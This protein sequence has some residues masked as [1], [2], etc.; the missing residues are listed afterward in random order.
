MTP[1]P[2]KTSA[3]L[4]ALAL[5]AFACAPDPSDGVEG[6]AQAV[7]GPGTTTDLEPGALYPG[8][9]WLTFPSG[10]GCTGTLISPSHVVT[11][12]HCAV[13]GLP[14]SMAFFDYDLTGFGESRGV[15]RC[16]VLPDYSDAQGVPADPPELRSQCG[17]LPGGVD[18]SLGTQY[19][20]AIV[21]LDRPVPLPW[22]AVGPGSF[23]TAFHRLPTTTPTAGDPLTIV[24]FGESSDGAGDFARRRYKDGVPFLLSS[25]VTGDA[26][27]YPSGTVFPGD[28]G[29]PALHDDGVTSPYALPVIAAH[30]RI[31]TSS[32]TIDLAT[33]FLPGSDNLAWLQ[34][35]MDLDADGRWDTMCDGE[36]Q[37]GYDPNI[38]PNLDTDGD[39]WEDSVDTEPAHYNPCQLGIDTDGDGLD[40][41]VD[42]C[43]LNPAPATV[44]SDTDGI[45][46]VCDLCPMV[47]SD[48][49]DTDEDGRGDP[50][51]ACPD[52]T[53]HP[54][55]L[56]SDGDGFY[57]DCDNCEDVF[58]PDQLDTDGADFIP[59]DGVGDACDNCP[60]LR[61]AGQENCNLDA[62]EALGLYDEGSGLYGL[63][64]ACDPNPCGETRRSSTTRYVNPTTRRVES[65]RLTIDARGDDLSGGTVDATTGFRYC[66][67]DDGETD[68]LDA[69]RACR[70]GSLGRECFIDSLLY[71]AVDD[72]A[73]WRRIA[74][75]SSLPSSASDI[76]AELSSFPYNPVEPRLSDGSIV[77]E[78]DLSTW[79]DVTSD[80]ARWTGPMGAPGEFNGV[81][82][83]RSIASNPPDDTRLQSH[84][85]AGP[86]ATAFDVPGPIPCLRYVGPYLARGSCPMCATSFPHPFVVADSKVSLC[87]SHGGPSIVIGD[88][89]LDL[90]QTS[91]LD[92]AWAGLVLPPELVNPGEPV[93]RLPA[94]GVRQLVVNSS[95]QVTSVLA[96]LANGEYARSNVSLPG[97]QLPSQGARG[98]LS[99][100]LER[101]FVVGGGN[102][103]W[104]QWIDPIGT[105]E[106]HAVRI[107]RPLGSVAA[108]TFDAVRQHIII[109]EAPDASAT[110]HTAW[111]QERELHL[112]TIDI[113][114][115][116]VR[117]I[118]G[119]DHGPGGQANALEIG[120]AVDAHG[121][122]LVVTHQ[123]SAS[124]WH[125]ELVGSAPSEA[126]YRKFGSD[127][128]YDAGLVVD[129]N[130]VS[131][132]RT[133]SGGERRLQGV[134]FDE[135]KTRALNEIEWYL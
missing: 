17:T 7:G 28:S 68:T 122:L 133:Y 60:A 34:A 106:W 71:T 8:V 127:P 88:G 30:S 78:R 50:C 70:D 65:G 113:H 10:G 117:T 37:G 66:L 107:S 132:I 123:Y 105:G 54:S 6:R 39:G 131:F 35:Q 77:F 84:Y 57:D 98:V 83:T 1:P 110:S 69:R 76:G 81:M 80:H 93:D 121:H 72:P 29:G 3:L 49:S 103:E 79:W 21:T 25:L 89:L 14:L 59:G 47:P 9:V 92:T 124:F 56:D 48:N 32:Y 85:W 26:L 104:L 24:G 55:F 23:R 114:T 5:T 63:G 97:P 42:P 15:A 64:D 13:R 86:A 27:E 4:A 43:P 134:H 111:Q 101:F 33:P 130:G 118:L 102:G 61:N 22:S 45:P 53:N 135:F 100:T 90:P 115:G 126:R 82:W 96:V 41:D 99:A 20:I 11:S 18:R 16:A 40:D 95:F 75:T 44:D 74:T 94:S 38:D 112:S 51:D 58:N 129:E 36:P 108:A 2:S 31:V 116:E 120:L 12:G 67:C 119:V 109:A 87:G 46:D 62:E 125:I 73:S 91:P 128:D 19:D 52:V